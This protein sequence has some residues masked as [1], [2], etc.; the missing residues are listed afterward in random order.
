MSVTSMVLGAATPG[1]A[2]QPAGGAAPAG[3]P[4]APAGNLPAAPVDI[5]PGAGEAHAGGSTLLGAHG[6]GASASGPAPRFKPGSKVLFCADGR[7][8]P[9]R[10]T[11]AKVDRG[12]PMH[13][14]GLSVSPAD[15]LTC[16]LCR[17]ALLVWRAPAMPTA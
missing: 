14:P 7:S 3:P 5:P 17:G 9:V 2:Q 4:E 8:A 16:N 10:G 12:A 11:V 15:V 13:L 6:E 1:T